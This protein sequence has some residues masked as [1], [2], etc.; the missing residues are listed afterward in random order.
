[1][2]Y[3]MCIYIYIYLYF[4]MTVITFERTFEKAFAK[5]CSKTS[6]EAFATKTTANA[7]AAPSRNRTF[8]KSINTCNNKLINQ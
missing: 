8:F 5:T 2:L 3:I 1:M 7:I 4:I 6:A